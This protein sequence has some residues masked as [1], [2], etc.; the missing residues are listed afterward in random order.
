MDL[1][2]RKSFPRMLLQICK[3]NHLISEKLEEYTMA[4]DEV[5]KQILD[6]QHKQNGRV[7]LISEDVKKAFLVSL[8]CGDYKYNVTQGRALK[9]LDEFTTEIRRVA[10]RLYSLAAYKSVR[11][12]VETHKT[13]S[14]NRLGSFISLICQD[15]ESSAHMKKAKKV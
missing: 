2:I 10:T 7:P 14:E 9:P 13:E 4:G 3:D 12:H 1:D 15:M 5:V 11:D 6:D 8:H